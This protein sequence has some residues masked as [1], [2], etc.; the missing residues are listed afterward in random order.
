MYSRLPTTY[1][2]IEALQ[3][4]PQAG[5]AA[6]RLA[7]VLWAGFVL[8]LSTDAGRR[9]RAGVMAPGA[10]AGAAGVASAGFS[11]AAGRLRGVL[12]RRMGDQAA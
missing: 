5:P 7:T 12:R 10:C 4:S 1:E 9:R 2:L 11:R 6:G 8:A 3:A